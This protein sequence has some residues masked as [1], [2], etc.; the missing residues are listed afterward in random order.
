MTPTLPNP[1]P[2]LLPF[3]GR[4][5]DGMVPAR[6]LWRCG[7]LSADGQ[8]SVMVLSWTLALS[9]S[10]LLAG[11]IGMTV[12]VHAPVKLLEKASAPL[13][14]ENGE[15][16]MLELS[17]DPFETADTSPSTELETVPVPFEP[18]AM[19]EVALEPLDLPEIPPVLTSE[20]IF[21]VP[22]AADI[23]PPLAVETPRRR[24]PA[25]ARPQTPSP[26]RSAPSTMASRSGTPSGSAGGGTG[27]TG[28]SA[29]GSKGYFPP[30][31]YPA[32][33]RSRGMQGTVYLTITFGE[34]GRVTSASIS[35]SSGYSDLDRAAADWVRRTWRGASGQTGTYRQPV[36]FRLR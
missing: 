9:L 3:T 6:C 23:E 32:A 19:P 24:D 34:D 15:L 30:P 12:P 14:N 16:A 18:V 17:S 7:T 29:R 13:S 5:Q 1:S 8:R 10:C 35:R 36:Q 25:P 27:G 22:A 26:A 28:T 31:P 11:G 21:Q 4:R 33:A 20:D 2:S